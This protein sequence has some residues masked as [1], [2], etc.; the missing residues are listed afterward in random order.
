MTFVNFVIPGRISTVLGQDKIFFAIIQ[1]TEKI[2]FQFLQKYKRRNILPFAGPYFKPHFRS[3]F[4]LTA[5][6]LGYK[7]LYGTLKICLL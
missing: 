1:N 3:K 2:V 4:D 7:E 5:F 6:K